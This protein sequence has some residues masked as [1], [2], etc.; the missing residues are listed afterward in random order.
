M[1]IQILMPALSPTMTEGNLAKWLKKEG[2]AVKSGDVIAEIETD[3][4]TME[5]EAAD[6]GRLGKIL[7]QAGTQGVAVNT[8]IAVLLEEGEDDSALAK[9]AAPAPA[10]AAAPAAA[11]APAASASAAAPAPQ[12]AAAPAPAAQGG[13][14]VFASPL[15]R[16]LAEQAGLDLKAVKGTG[17][18]GRIVKADIEAA[19]AGGTAKAAAPQAAAPAP[20]A[21]PAAAPAAAAP[22]PKAAGIDAKDLSDKLGMRYKAQ[23]NSSMRKTISRR[24]TEVQQTVPDYFLAI[25]CELDALLKVRSDLNARS[26]DYKLSVNDFIIRA[27]ALTLKK[28]PNINAAWSEEAI[29]RYDHVDISVAVA[30]PTGLITP[31]V[32]KAET[33]GLAEIS[34]EMKGLAERARDGKLKP[35]EY[36]GGTFSI[37][38][39]GMY[40]IREFAA[41]INPPQAC[42]MAVGAGEQRPVVKNGALAIATVM[43]VSVTVD[44]RVADGAQGAEFLAAFKKLIEDPLSMLL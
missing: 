40:G 6:E 20:A 7:V 5:V 31:I 32:K 27:A 19:K 38:N 9:A 41:I 22:A 14:R 2:D 11:P 36:Q 12:A 33:K 8:P 30:T 4:A 15:A 13:G 43:T 25:D 44:H 17:P 23:P 34:N 35:E 10:P 39:L 1:T 24:L 37:S 29:L 26:K 28:F 16:R 3:K 18:N 42:I 21:V